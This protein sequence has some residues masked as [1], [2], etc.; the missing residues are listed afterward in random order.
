[1]NK[2]AKTSLRGRTIGRGVAAKVKKRLTPTATKTGNPMQ[3]KFE[4]EAY[5]MKRTNI[6]ILPPNGV[7]PVSG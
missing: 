6:N 7:L 2:S 3:K 4:A 5:R 1:M